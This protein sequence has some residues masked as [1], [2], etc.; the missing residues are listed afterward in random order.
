MI[1]YDDIYGSLEKQVKAVKVWSKVLERRE[2][3][4][5]HK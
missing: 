1:Q 5:S 3:L 4:L 2:Y